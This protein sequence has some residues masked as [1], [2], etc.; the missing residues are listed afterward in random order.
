MRIV[1]TGNARFI[2]H[3]EISGSDNL[4]NVDVQEVKVQVPLPITSNEIVVPTIIKQPNNVKQ[5]INEPLLHN[6]MLTNEQ[7]V[8]E[9]QEI[10]LRRSQEERNFVISDDYMVYLHESDFDIGTSKDLISFSQ[11]IKSVD[12]IK[13]MDTMKDE[14]KSMNQNKVWDL[15]K[16][17][18]GYKK[19][20]SKWVFKAKRD[21][22]GNIERF[23][24]RLVAKGFIK[25]EG[26]DY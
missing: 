1:E 3:G 8:E 4:R 25:K 2:E 9:P 5:Q 7:V 22:K 18:E 12:S 16:L 11:A 17:P 21:S 23:K 14:M 24:A 26:I 6:E 10:V 13:W 20:G 19:V 15:V